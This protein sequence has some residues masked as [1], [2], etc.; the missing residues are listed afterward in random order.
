MLKKGLRKSAGQILP[1]V[2]L[3]IFIAMISATWMMSGVVPAMI[4]YGVRYLN[5]TTFL[6]TA[7][8][9][10][11]VVSVMTGSS[12]TTIATIGVAFI[13]IGKIMGY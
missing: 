8:V 12:W 2:P 10:C 7:C 4:D 1:A 6:A 5:P 3:L 11:A 13:G 9:I